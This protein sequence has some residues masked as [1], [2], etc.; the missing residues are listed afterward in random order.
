MSLTPIEGDNGDRGGAERDHDTPGVRQRVR[1]AVS[2]LL[3]RAA[4]HLRA[5]VRGAA[6][7]GESGS[8]DRSGGDA[9]AAIRPGA[10]ARLESGRDG[11]RGGQDATPELPIVAG[12]DRPVEATVDGDSLRIHRPDNREAYISS[13]VYQRVRR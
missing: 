4:E 10:Q 2:T 1:R 11:T 3:G 13:D 7:T 6:D 8:D 12:T 5:A 9:A